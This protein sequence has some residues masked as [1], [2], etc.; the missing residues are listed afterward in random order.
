MLPKT[1]N[2]WIALGGSLIALAVTVFAC[3]KRTRHWFIRL[4]D[5]VRAHSKFIEHFGSQYA[6]SIAELL[7][8]L[9]TAHDLHEA[10]SRIILRRLGIGIY[11]TDAA[12]GK[13]LH[14]TDRLAEIFG[15]PASEML[16]FGW[17]AQIDDAAKKVEYWNWCIGKQ[18][19]YR[20]SY[21][22]TNATTGKRVA[23]HTEAFFLDADGGR[24]VGYVEVVGEVT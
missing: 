19:T 1:I 4:R 23:C 13:C 3:L 22:V 8:D 17:A 20:D 6:T 10:H 11:I 24:Y 15:I 9:G 7:C 18:L 21:T 16:G 12:T 14:V 2:E 5:N